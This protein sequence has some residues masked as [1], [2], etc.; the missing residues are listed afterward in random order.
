MSEKFKNYLINFLAIF[1]IVAAIGILSWTYLNWR[2]AENIVNPERV[3]SF[4]AQGKVFAKPDIARLTF[5]VI[6]QKE[7]AEEAQKE[8]DQKIKTLVDF[9]KSEGIEDKD[10]KT[11]NYSLNPQ[12][13]Y[14]WCRKDTKDFNSCPPKIIGYQLDQTIEIK[15]RD[16]D[17]INS[18]V[19]Q[20][21]LKGANE[22]SDISFEIDDQEDYKN[23]AR[24][25]AFNKIK[26]RVKLFE[27]ETG[28]K[29]GKIISISEEGGY[30]PLYRSAV[31]EA[32]LSMG[33][34]STPVSAIEPGT[35]EITVN[36]IVNYALK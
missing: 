6:T 7:K 12:Y 30:V 32:N 4:S 34:A 15:I 16:F 14:S 13:D 10:I 24:V 5:S 20:L 26:N 23:L 25:E 3:I 9:V 36:L 1:L 18:L 2:Q 31:K 22:I 8:N 17:K 27:V 28:V 35:N 29:I 19:G 21:S 11:I 33:A